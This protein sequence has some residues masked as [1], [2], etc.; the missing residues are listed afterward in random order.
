MQDMSYVD[1]LDAR[2]GP[3]AYRNDLLGSLGE[4]G[5]RVNLMPLSG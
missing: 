1:A 4:E 5:S 2:L 3:V